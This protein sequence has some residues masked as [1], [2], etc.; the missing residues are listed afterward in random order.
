LKHP[1]RVAPVAF[2]S[3]GKRLLTLCNGQVVLGWTDLLPSE[4]N[5]FRQDSSVRVWD[6][7]TGAVVGPPIQVA[8]TE[9]WAAAISPDGTRVITG[10]NDKMA[11]IWDVATG[12]L[13]G[14][15]LP[16]DDFVTCVAFSPDGKKAAAGVGN[17]ISPDRHSLL[18]K[19]VGVVARIIDV[20][21]CQLIGAPLVHEDQVISV[22]FSPDG[23][24]IVTGSDDATARV[25]DATTGASA[26]R[27]MRHNSPVSAVFSSDG[28]R[29]LTH[30]RFGA[31]V[32]DMHSGEPLGETVGRNS[33]MWT[34]FSPDGRR[35]LTLEDATTVQLWDAIT[36]Q[37]IGEPWYS[38][39]PILNMAFT[40]DNASLVMITNRTIRIES[41]K[42]LPLPKE[43]QA[44]F[45]ILLGKRVSETEE[46]VWLTPNEIADR[47]KVLGADHEWIKQLHDASSDEIRGAGIE[48]L[49]KTFERDIMVRNTLAADFRD[50]VGY[51]V[52]VAQ[53]H[54]RLASVLETFDKEA[55]A[56]LEC[57]AA[58]NEL[59]DLLIKSPLDAK[60]KAELAKTLN[61]V[62][63]LRATSLKENVR[64]GKKAIELATKACELTGYENASFVD[65]LA[66]AYAEKGEFETAIKWSEKSLALAKQNG[67]AKLQN[68]L[69]KALVTYKSRQPVRTKRDAFAQVGHGKKLEEATKA[70]VEKTKVSAARM[71]DELRYGQTTATKAVE[72]A[73]SATKQSGANSVAVPPTERSPWKLEFFRWPDTGVD[74]LPKDWAAVVSQ[75]P[76]FSKQVE[77][78]DFEWGVSAP[79]QKVP[80]DHFAI[81][82]TTTIAL[83]SDKT[84]RMTA[85]SD[86]GIRVYVDDKRVIENW[87]VHQPARNMADVPLKKGNHVLRIEYFQNSGAATLKFDYY[88]FGDVTKSAPKE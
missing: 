19:S 6:V 9:I 4:K 20:A 69:A 31:R 7:A 51:R 25:W 26:S 71:G 73:K 38:D 13:I 37:K 59:S 30:T 64:D 53:S 18:A 36:A 32:W 74:G 41:V 46:L 66:A 2:S 87:N 43:K 27:P 23:S 72:A 42:P 39:A 63:W 29:I 47:W 11:R 8:N 14:K 40:P 10:S 81:V 52:D 22:D 5:A 70:T 45:E 44:W 88:S 24:H 34:E 55:E 60:V 84:L 3:D 62:A 16:L 17:K 86:D 15:P 48:D 80:Q 85:H 54:T 68:S 50:V 56:C 83:P 75:T 1:S 49:R 28:Q 77:R 65:S 33:V 61:M 12:L 67:N 57:E 21:K 76:I 79:H 82:A 78:I 35:V 58:I